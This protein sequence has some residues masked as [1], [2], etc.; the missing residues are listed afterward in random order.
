[1]VGTLPIRGRDL[2]DV[3]VPY[4]SFKGHPATVGTTTDTGLADLGV[5]AV[6]KIEN[7]RA[8]GEGKDI[9]AGSEA[10]NVVRIEINL[11]GIE[12]LAR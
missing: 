10:V 11:E 1:V 3:A 7:G 2:D 4:F 6:C 9:A 8:A 5:D 12:K